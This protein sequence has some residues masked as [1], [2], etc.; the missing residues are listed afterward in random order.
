M[1]G[2]EVSNKF[3]GHF[4]FIPLNPEPGHPILAPGY[5]DNPTDYDFDVGYG[6][7]IFPE[8]W[9]WPE[10]SNDSELKLMKELGGLR[11]IN[12][13]TAL[14]PWIHYDW[15]SLDF[16][17]LEVWNGGMRHDR[18]D[19]DA[20]HGEHRCQ[21]HLR[22][23]PIGNKM[24]ESDIERSW[25]GM[26]KTGRWPMIAVGGSDTH[27]FN[28]SVCFDG[29]CDPTS[30]EIGLPATSV[31]AP[32]FVWANGQTGIADGLARGRTVVHDFSN[33]IDLRIVYKGIEYIVGDTIENYEPGDPLEIRAFGRVAKFVD[34]D[35]RPLLIMGTNGD[36]QDSRVRVLYNS[37]DE[38]HFAKLLKGKDHMRYI[39]ADSNF[40]KKQLT[41]LKD[42]DVGLNRVYF[43]FAQLIPF[44]NPIYVQGNGQD[45]ALTG[46]I[47]IQAT[48]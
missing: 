48:Q 40:D 43:V 22:R 37:E 47:R 33:F 44:H 32:E 6:V 24:P 45:M 36:F 16:D 39:R 12:H 27:K 28:D 11:I 8:R 9:I 38:V 19:D 29:P 18:F 42:A 15:S 41:S 21:R 26:L 10:A 13:E 2:S 30:A 4:G 20:Y 46:A 35:N 17:G 14:A 7:G 23:K 5:T 25:L 3:N 31:F 34:G 1:V